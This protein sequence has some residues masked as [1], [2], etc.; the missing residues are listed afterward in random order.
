MK[1]FSEN[2]WKVLYWATISD[3]FYTAATIFG[4]NLP[5]CSCVFKQ[6]LLALN[7]DAHSAKNVKGAPKRMLNQSSNNSGMPDSEVLL[8]LDALKERK[9][10]VKEDWWQYRLEIP[11]PD[12][13][14]VAAL[15]HP[16]E[17]M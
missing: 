2:A 3:L 8:W 14:N 7:R 9:A 5:L 15:Q 12:S 10:S 1:N 4:H 11:I 13:S 6:E 17:L 16:L